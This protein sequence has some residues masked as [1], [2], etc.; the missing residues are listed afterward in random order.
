VADCM[1]RPRQYVHPVAGELHLTVT[2]LAVPAH[3]DLVLFVETPSDE[4][5]RERLPLTRRDLERTGA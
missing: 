3:P 4:I 1:P 2:E 5:T